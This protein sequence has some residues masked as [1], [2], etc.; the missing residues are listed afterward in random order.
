MST[1]RGK[2]RGLAFLRA[3]IDYQGDDCVIWP[4]GRD[5][6]GYGLFGYNGGRSIRAHRWMC[7][8]KHGQA[9]T[10]KHYAAHECGNGHLGCVNPKHLKWKTQDEN[11][12]DAIRHGTTRTGKGRKLRKLTHDQVLDI[13][14][15]KGLKTNAALSKIYGVC[16]RHIRLIQSGGSWRGGMPQMTKGRG[17]AEYLISPSLRTDPQ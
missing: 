6:D 12:L 2:G 14:A 1:V 16:D 13:I 7:E 10:E 8:Q 9:P 3:H 4:M 11:A 5:R 15:L 17:V